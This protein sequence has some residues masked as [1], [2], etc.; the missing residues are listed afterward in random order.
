MTGISPF[1]LL[2]FHRDVVSSQIYTDAGVDALIVDLENKGK[3]ARQ[4]GFDT[5]INTH[6]LFDLETVKDKTNAHVMCRINGPNPDMKLEIAD[7]LSAGADEIIVPMIRNI[8]QAC[9]AVDCVSG[10]AK[11]TLMVETQEALSFVPALSAL[12]IDRIYI[13]LND[14]QISRG[15]VSIFSSLID[16]SLDKVRS[17]VKG[18]QFGFGGLTLRGMGDPLPVSHFVADLARLRAEFTF[19]RRSFYRDVRTQNPSDALR[20]MKEDI[21]DAKQRNQVQVASDYQALKTAVRE[22]EAA[23][24]A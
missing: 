9:A 10:D 19:L 12:P 15:T 1:Q 22:L 2:L 16:G 13:G 8:D 21:H 11:I 7:V 17:G 14:L 18:V 3:G 6:N 20:Q 24:N 4:V 5:E 23:L